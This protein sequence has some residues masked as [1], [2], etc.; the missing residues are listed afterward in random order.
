MKITIHRANQIGGCITVVE[1][2]E[3]KIIID[4]GNNLPGNQH[5]ELGKEEINEITEGVNAIFYTHCHG[6]HTGLHHLADPRIPQ[7]IGAGAQE[8]MVCKY[9]TLAKYGDFSQQ[10]ISAQR[11]KNYRAGK[12]VKYSGSDKIKVTPYF[13][14][15]SAFDAYMFKIECDS[16]KI[17]HT[18]DFRK[19]GYLGKG[20]FPTL[21]KYVGQ[22]DILI[23]ESTM[24]GRRQETVISENDIKRNVVE[25]LKK[26]K[27][28]NPTIGVIPIHKDEDTQYDMDKVQGYKIFKES[29]IVSNMLSIVIE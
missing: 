25:V 2:D 4:L 19:H 12:P 16:I 18:G 23:T 10:L 24:P 7:Y 21:E 17:L 15:H 26:H 14:S 27:Y 22:V 20:L 6:D 1:H 5:A 29:E 8:I 3:C 13:V 28:V 9:E 11:M